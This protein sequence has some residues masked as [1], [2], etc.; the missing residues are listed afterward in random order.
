ML[1]DEV[2]E[3]WKPYRVGPVFAGYQFANLLWNLPAG[4]TG[5]I[6]SLILDENYLYFATALTV[7][8]DNYKITISRKLIR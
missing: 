5:A 3:D 8:T 7:S 2:L 4:H 6:A 1:Y